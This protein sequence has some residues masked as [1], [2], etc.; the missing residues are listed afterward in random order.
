MTQHGGDNEL[1]S[2]LNEKN[3]DLNRYLDEIRVRIV[4]VDIE[5][6]NSLVCDLKFS[7]NGNYH[8]F[9]VRRC[10]I[11]TVNWKRS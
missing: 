2:K 11:Q 7:F 4:V 9:H 3:K 5:V 1:R 6:C 10:Q 8:L